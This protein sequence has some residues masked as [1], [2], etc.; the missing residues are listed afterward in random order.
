VDQPSSLLAFASTGPVAANGLYSERAANPAEDQ[1]DS[2][3]E[4]ANL[5]EPV[6]TAQAPQEQGG[7]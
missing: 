1:A 3:Q 6:A 4:Q 5:L 7:C 2:E